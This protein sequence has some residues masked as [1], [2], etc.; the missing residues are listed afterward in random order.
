[1][2]KNS[3]Q[4]GTTK[5]KLDE[6]KNAKAEFE[7]KN[8]N[9]DSAKYRLGISSFNAMISDLEKQL[10]EYNS[11]INNEHHELVNHTIEDLPHILIKAR[12]AKRMSQNDLAKII[13]IDEQQIQR[14]EATNYESASWDRMV[15]VI[16]ALDINIRMKEILVINSSFENAFNIPSYITKT[17]LQAAEKRVIANRQ[18]L[19][20]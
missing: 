9:K 5:S 2:I 4:A 14:Y 20:I 19:S 10:L 13:G 11:L 18:L 3:K 17:K 16:L 15:D 12:L 8:I 6:M 1:M 7:K